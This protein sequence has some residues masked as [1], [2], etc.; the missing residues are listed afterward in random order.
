FTVSEPPNCLATDG[1]LWPPIVVMKQIFDNLGIP[2]NQRLYAL[3]YYEHRKCSTAQG[4]PCVDA[5][6]SIWADQTLQ[7]EV[8]STIGWSSGARVVAY[9]MGEGGPVEPSWTTS[10][11]IQDIASLM[12]RYRIDGGSFWRSTSFENSE[13]PD[14]TLAEPIKRR[15]VEFNYTPAKEV[16]EC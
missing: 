6:P 7:N 1:H 9:E 5:S 15:G 10:Q 13:D 12:A 2:N 14:P 8:F 4:L 11:A 3:S 16:L